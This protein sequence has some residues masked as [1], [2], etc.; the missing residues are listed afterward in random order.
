[1]TLVEKYLEGKQPQ[2]KSD[3]VAAKHSRFTRPA[4]PGVDEI[5][6]D[7][8]GKC[9]TKRCLCKNHLRKCNPH[10]CSC[11]TDACKDI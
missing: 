2:P 8:S 7:C 9:A 6:C 10:A 4:L 11:K 5:Y 3:I 1:M